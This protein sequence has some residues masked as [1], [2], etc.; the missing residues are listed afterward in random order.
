MYTGEQNKGAVL[1]RKKSKAALF[2]V[3]R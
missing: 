3:K 2:W 1:L